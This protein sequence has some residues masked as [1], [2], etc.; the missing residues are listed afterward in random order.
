MRQKKELAHWT[1]KNGFKARIHR[2]FFRCRYLQRLYEVYGQTVELSSKLKQYK[3][4]S[5]SNFLVKLTKVLFR[6]MIIEAFF[7]FSTFWFTYKSLS[8]IDLY[9]LLI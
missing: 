5:D 8:A 2:F 7:T 1:K 3:F 4:G 6:V 9:D